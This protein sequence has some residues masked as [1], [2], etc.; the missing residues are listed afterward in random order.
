MW[1]VIP[2]FPRSPI[3]ILPTHCSF[4][5]TPILSFCRVVRH[6][7]ASDGP[8]DVSDKFRIEIF[9]DNK[10]VG[11]KQ[12]LSTLIKSKRASQASPRLCV[13]LEWVEP[14]LWSCVC[15][16]P[17]TTRS[18]Q[19]SGTCRHPYP[20]RSSLTEED[21]VITCGA[22]RSTPAGAGRREGRRTQT[23]VKDITKK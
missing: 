3:P 12:V 6:R 15:R 18:Q 21:K 7:L 8:Y 19:T 5:H 13:S 2:L 23:Q 20:M 14:S 1:F 9:L 17:M 4:C 16:A 10:P 22:G 11:R